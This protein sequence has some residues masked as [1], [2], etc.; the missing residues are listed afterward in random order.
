[1]AVQPLFGKSENLSHVLA[2]KINKIEGCLTFA[3]FEWECTRRNSHADLIDRSIDGVDLISDLC[4]YAIDAICAVAY[5][6]MQ[7]ISTKHIID[8][9]KSIYAN[10]SMQTMYRCIDVLISMYRYRIISI[11]YRSH[12]NRTSEHR[13]RWRVLRHCIVHLLGVVLQID[14]QGNEDS[15]YRRKGATLLIAFV[16]TI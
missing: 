15:H 6:F 14:I 9:C 13:S 3:A 8:L 11:C 7:S 12:I 4:R 10:R 1:M 2:A 5:R 16:E